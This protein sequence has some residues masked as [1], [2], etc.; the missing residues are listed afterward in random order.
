MTDILENCVETVRILTRVYERRGSFR[1]VP[2][3]IAI[4]PDGRIAAREIKRAGKGDVKP[5]QHEVA[6]TLRDLFGWKLDLA[7]VEWHCRE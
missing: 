3:V 4:F 7:V 1:G 6:D 2:D 5:N